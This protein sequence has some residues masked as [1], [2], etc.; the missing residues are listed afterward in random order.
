MFIPM[1][2]WDWAILIL[3]AVSLLIFLWNF[4]FSDIPEDFLGMIEKNKTK[5]KD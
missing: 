2:F 3:G 5:N 1:T 4:V